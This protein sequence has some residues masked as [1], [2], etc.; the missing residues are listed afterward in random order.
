MRGLIFLACLIEKFVVCH[1]P[2]EYI[3]REKKE[4]F[5]FRVHVK[6]LIAPPVH[7]ILRSLSPLTRN[8]KEEIARNYFC[9]FSPPLLIGR[10]KNKNLCHWSCETF[11][12]P[13]GF[14][15]FR[16]PAHFR[17]ASFMRLW[18]AKKKTNS[19][20]LMIIKSFYVTAQF[21]YTNSNFVCGFKRTWDLL[22][23]TT[24]QQSFIALFL[25][26][27]PCFFVLPPRHEIDPPHQISL[28][29]SN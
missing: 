8:A 12:F 22:I 27:L 14:K 23:F 29:K 18:L 24:H 1:C 3:R 11:F 2:V 4:V 13:F 5:F 16:F 9:R 6:N 17:M 20:A 15:F 7:F 10:A 28:M 25:C 21:A 26:S 19:L